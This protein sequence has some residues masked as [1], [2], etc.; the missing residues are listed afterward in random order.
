MSDRYPALLGVMCDRCGGRSEA[1]TTETRLGYVFDWTTS[2]WWIVEDRR[3]PLS[4][5]TFCPDYPDC[6]EQ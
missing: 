6:E 5:R 2:N 1:D 4:T 3:H